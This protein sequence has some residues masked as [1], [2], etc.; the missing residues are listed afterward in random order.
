[1]KTQIAEKQIQQVSSSEYL[2]SHKFVCELI[3]KETGL[4]CLRR[5]K[6][7]G[8]LQVHHRKH[9]GDKPFPCRHDDCQKYFSTIGNRNDHEL[10]HQGLKPYKCDHCSEC[11]YRLYMLKKHLINKHDS[12]YNYIG[13]Q[14]IRRSMSMA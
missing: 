6:E 3:D 4:P 7:K 10:R 13:K 12:V 2:L 9:T 1:V 5:F 8:N 11:Y 14:K